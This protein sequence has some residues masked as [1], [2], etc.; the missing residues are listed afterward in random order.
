MANTNSIE[1]AA[2]IG[3]APQQQPDSAIV[4]GKVRRLRASYNVAA[5]GAGDTLTIGKLPAGASFMAGYITASATM[6][7]AATIAIGIA[8]TTGKYRTAAIHTT[9]DQPVLFGNAAA[10]DDP[11]LAADETLIATI[12]VA[13]L[14]G[15]GILIF[16]I[17]YTTRA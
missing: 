12:A 8:G 2:V 6:G 4:A 13:A 17:L 3:T 9:V 1:I 5:Q 14:P 16:D 10:K 7:A 11:A 15:A